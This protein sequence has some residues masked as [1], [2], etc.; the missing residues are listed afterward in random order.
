MIKLRVPTEIVIMLTNRCN[1]NCV[2][3]ATSE[4][5]D[6]AITEE[7][8]AEQWI[9]LLYRLAELKVFRLTITG[10]EI[11][12]R[13]DIME[14][15]EVACKL[16]PKAV[17]INTNGTVFN[18]KL[19]DQLIQ[20]NYMIIGTSIDGT[21]LVHDKLRGDGSYEKTILFIKS[22]VE[23]NAIFEVCFVPTRMNYKEFP[24]LIERLIEIGVTRFDYN[25]LSAEGNCYY[26]YK[27]LALKF[28]DEQREFMN[29][30]K[31]IND[32]YNLNLPFKYQK[33]LS[34][35][36]K[37]IALKNN[38]R[39]KSIS[40]PSLW[41]CSA[42]KT[43][44]AILPDGWLIPCSAFYQFKGGNV[45]DC[46]FLDAWNTSNW[47][48]IFD[49]EQFT[50]KDIPECTNCKYNIL[51]GAGCKGLNY[52]FTGKLLAPDIECPYLDQDKLFANIQNNKS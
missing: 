31:G 24:I 29:I 49:L 27:E 11:F 32:K 9:N 34:L 4:L 43:S 46:D 22:L 21:K 35:E 33:Y 17:K 16:F 7:L 13:K 18:Q 2:F 30:I 36:D 20:L 40:P 51:C 25:T 47:N 15:L 48:A 39:T 8:T 10:G 50:S 5:S 45:K 44:C 3:C 1:L 41:N 19:I 38:N 28:P 37:Y 14:I 52:L 12:I 6:K 26:S 42:G 23:R